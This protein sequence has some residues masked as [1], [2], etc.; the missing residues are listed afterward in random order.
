MTKDLKKYES[1]TDNLK[2][3]DGLKKSEKSEK[4][5]VTPSSIHAKNEFCGGYG[6]LGKK[7]IGGK[8]DLKMA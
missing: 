8:F 2:A 6:Y 5:V 4:K 3:K 7:K 1:L